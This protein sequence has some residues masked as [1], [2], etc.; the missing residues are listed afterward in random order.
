M[1]YQDI[2]KDYKSNIKQITIAF[3]TKIMITLITI[4]NNNDHASPI[5]TEG[6]IVKT[7]IW[8]G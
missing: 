1:A 2:S 3:Q 5:T 7:T 8:L 4:K 6:N